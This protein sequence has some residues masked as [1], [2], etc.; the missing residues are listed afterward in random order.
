VLRID[1]Q[2]EKA[3]GGT[4][5]KID[6][7]VL[8]EGKEIPYEAGLSGGMA[9]ATGLSLDLALGAVLSR[10]QNRFPGWLILDE[11]F[12][13]LGTIS[14]E[15]CLEMLSKHVSG[16]LVLVVD[17]NSEFHGLFDHVIEIEMIDGESRVV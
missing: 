2:R 8:A 12:D 17:H 16:R 14:K 6:I 7:K 9:A 10:R 5:N 3:S 15:S 1:S 13:G 4:Q 11:A